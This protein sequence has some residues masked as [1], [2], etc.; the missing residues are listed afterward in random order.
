MT[1][2]QQAPKEETPTEDTP[3]EEA[4]KEEAP[5]EETPKEDTPKEETPK[6]ET[7][8]EETPKEETP[9]EETPKEEAPHGANPHEETP[10]E[11]TPQGDT[12]KEDVEIEESA[13]EVEK[14]AKDNGVTEEVMKKR[15]VLIAK[16][17]KLTVWNHYTV[18][19]QE[20]LRRAIIKDT[21]VPR[22]WQRVKA[23]GDIIDPLN[24]EFLQNLINKPP[25][26]RAMMALLPRVD[27]EWT[28]E[29]A[30]LSLWYR[31]LLDCQKRT[32]LRYIIRGEN[33]PEGYDTWRGA[34]WSLSGKLSKWVANN[35][36]GIL[37]KECKI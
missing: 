21:P 35:R 24:A 31:T 13:E 4:P 30:T 36:E 15:L 34:V 9:S 10:I 6:E 14:L 28:V 18:I 26:R 11:E 22:M 19:E 20:R 2:T 1:T 8:K 29:R 12:P 33:I 32:V 7:P 16:I 17:K 5:K 3:L 27:N 25:L 37:S 23:Y